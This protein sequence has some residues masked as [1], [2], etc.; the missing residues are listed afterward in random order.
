VAIDWIKMRSN[1]Q[2]HPKIVRI[3]SATTSDKFRVIGG[4][5]AVWS[6]FDAH[7]HDGVLKGYTPELMDHVIGWSGF[8][9]AMESVGWLLFDGIETLSLPEFDEHNSQSAKRRAEDQ[10]RKRNARN[11]PDY[12]QEDADKNRTES[13]LDKIRKEKKYINYADGVFDVSENYI[14]LWSKSYPQV[15][16]QAELAKAGSWCFTNPS[17]APKSAYARFLNGWL[18]RANGSATTAPAEPSEQQDCEAW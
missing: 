3:L 8:S 11:S 7:T 2:S 12:V 16:I 10:K 6:V 17:K 14:Q 1:L 18:S 9:R 5:H 4:L 13:G 15:S